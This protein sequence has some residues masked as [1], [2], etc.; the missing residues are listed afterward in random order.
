MFASRK[1]QCEKCGCKYFIS[2]DG[3]E[4]SV[5]YYC[6]GCG[7]SFNATQEMTGR[8]FTCPGCGTKFPIPGAK[9]QP[10]QTDVYMPA[11]KDKDKDTEDGGPK[12]SIDKGS[13]KATHTATS[14]MKILCD[15]PECSAEY[16]LGKDREGQILQCE[17]CGTSFQ[18]P[19]LTQPPPE[20]DTAEIKKDLERLI[21][22]VKDHLPSLADVLERAL[23]EI[24]KET[25]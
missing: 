2:P 1:V 24:D 4:V 17:S 19:L 11:P 23:K 12:V 14:R 6:P 3:K 5:V 20:K 18:V 16:E 8:L 7:Q 25:G 10:T 21:E 15:C 22:Q 9:R 13:A